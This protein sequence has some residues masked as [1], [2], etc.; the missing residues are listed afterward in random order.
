MP[1]DFLTPKWT[2]KMVQQVL[3]LGTNILLI[4][5]RFFVDIGPDLGII[6]VARLK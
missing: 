5:G 4:L 2:P 3:R 1:V 6:V